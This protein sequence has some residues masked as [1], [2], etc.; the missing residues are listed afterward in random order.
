MQTNTSPAE[1]KAAFG[2]LQALAEA[3]RELGEVPSGHLFA[4]LQDRLT[5]SQFEQAIG[6]LKR[7]GLVRESNAHLLT[8]LE[9]KATA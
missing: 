1:I 9:P 7:S 2:I 5:L 6:V 8:W 3:I 4:S